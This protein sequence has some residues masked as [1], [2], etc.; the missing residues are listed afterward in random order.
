VAADR[1][2]AGSRGEGGGAVIDYLRELEQAGARVTHVRDEING[3]GW[4]VDWPDGYAEWWYD[5]GV[6]QA[7]SVSVYMTLRKLPPSPGMLARLGLRLWQGW[8]KMLP[9]LRP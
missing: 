7:S 4:R 2:A 8:T 6:Y 3:E 5:R 9:L 1:M